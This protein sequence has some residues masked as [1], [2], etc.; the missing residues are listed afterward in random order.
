MKN[1][2]KYIYI[3]I[4]VWLMWFFV[5]FASAVNC[6]PMMYERSWMWCV[7]NFCIWH[8]D[9]YCA[10]VKNAKTQAGVR[11]ADIKECM[12]GYYDSDNWSDKAKW[13]QLFCECI[14]DWWTELAVSIPFVSVVNWKDYGR[15]IP[16][17]ASG[18]AVPRL[19]YSIIQILNT[20]L[21]VGGFTAL[22]YAGV[23]YT[24]QWFDNDWQLKKA[25]TIIWWV[26]G[27]F[28]FYGTLWLI[29]KLINPNFFQ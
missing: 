6:D 21:L 3:S 22:I 14:A 26:I 2:S 10:D 9:K 12:W 18:Q 29:L 7:S 20:L 23:L 15:C 4:I 28:A 11:D 24:T 8:S 5:S 17:A 19:I 16:K 1:L 13:W 25:K 27:A